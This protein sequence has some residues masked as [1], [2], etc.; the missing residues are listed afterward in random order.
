M[1]ALS[2]T[3]GIDLELWKSPIPPFDRKKRLWK[4]MRRSWGERGRTG[5][6]G[7]PRV[8]PRHGPRLIHK[9]VPSASVF[10]GL[11]H[12]VFHRPHR[13]SGTPDV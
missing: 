8:A 6:V 9:E 1:D 4:R 7:I 11:L 10:R 3:G 13:G 2:E 5:W 12:M